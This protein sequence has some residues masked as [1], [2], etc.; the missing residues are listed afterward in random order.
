MMIGSTIIL[1]VLYNLYR[2]H[3]SSHIYF[4]NYQGSEVTLIFCLPL[5]SH[6]DIIL[7]I[8]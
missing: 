8:P 5:A 1:S 3:Y 4:K 2:T 6:V 7:Q